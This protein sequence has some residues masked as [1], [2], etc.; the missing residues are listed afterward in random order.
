MRSLGAVAVGVAL[1]AGLI[2]PPLPASAQVPQGDPRKVLEL[3]QTPCLPGSDVA[4]APTPTASPSTVPASQATFAPSPTPTP[5]ASPS[6][7]PLPVVPY[8][9]GVLVPPPLPSTT[10]RVTPPPLP[11]PSAAPSGPAGPI[12]IAPVTPTPVPTATAVPTS[13]PIVPARPTPSPVPSPGE[14]LGPNDYAVLGDELV[15]N[16]GEGPWDLTGHVNILYQDG[17]LV[18]DRAHYDGERYIDVTGNTYLQNREGDT[19]MAA[20]SIRFDTRNQNATLINGRGVTTQGVQQGRLHFNGRNM[21]T[22]RNG[23][24]HADRASF[25]TCE[26]PH[27]GYHIESKT[28]DIYP[29][30]RAVARAAVLFLGPLAI[31]YLPVLVIP[32]RRETDRRRRTGPIVPLIGYDQAE[33]YWIKARIGFDHGPTYFGYY[34]VEA[35]TKIGIGLGYVATIS[36]KDGRRVTNVD[37]FRLKNNQTNSE[38]TNLAINDQ[39]NFSQRVKGTARFTYQGNYG[40]L[41]DLPPSLSVALG[42][43]KTIGKDAENFS[44]ARQSTGTQFSSN[45]YGF[46]DTYTASPRLSNATTVSYTTNSSSSGGVSTQ[47]DS[48]HFNTDTHFTGRTVDYDLTI[49]R[50]DATSPSGVD[51][52]PELLI[53]PH[54]PIFSW[55]H[56]FPTTATFTVGEYSDPIASLA[57]QRAEAQFNFGPALAHTLLGD[58]N[59]TVNV[60]QDIYGTGDAKANIQQQINL[61]SPIGSHITNTLSY[62]NQHVN[63]L[64]NEPFTF[65]T[66]GGSTKNLQEVLRVYNGDA[67]ALSLQTGTAFNMMAQPITYQLLT[68]PAKNVQFLAGGAWTPGAGFG[69]D[70]TNVQIATPLG[71]TTD[72]QISTFVD[73]KNKGRLESKNMYLRTIIADCYEIRVA[74]NQDLKTVNITVDLLAFPSQAVNFGLGQTTSIIPQSFASDQFFNGAR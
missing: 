12:Y 31:F 15:G 27:R 1:I 46:T 68:R 8:G 7:V 22:E 2:V 55:W 50:Y 36:R 51:K 30:D 70:R 73:W 3:I 44:F 9:P 43:T 62:A 47:N 11:T 16:R 5:S 37:Y 21:V 72:F 10:P 63:G 40:P 58:F 49:D 52:L 69:F 26:N 18:G 61:S 25:T 32:L 6:A 60:R 67:Y 56:A 45:N 34:R 57:T 65:D 28:L 66:I 71:K 53:R 59:A 23:R 24:T 29:G 17:A 48:L 35:Y 41:I 74:Y 20:D 42:L 13:G 4:Q 38:S 64:G 14:T 39:E 19:T 54:G 33:G